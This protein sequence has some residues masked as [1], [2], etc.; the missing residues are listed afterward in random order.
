MVSHHRLDL[1]A[2]A[3]CSCHPLY[4]MNMKMLSFQTIVVNSAQAFLCQY[5][6]C[7]L[8]AIIHQA[9]PERVL[10]Q[11]MSKVRREYWC[12]ITDNRGSRLLAHQQAY[13]TKY[14]WLCGFCGGYAVASYNITLL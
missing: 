10:T 12:F 6:L 3:I 5:F 7:F 1:L 11:D 2:Y 14:S 9:L 13:Y 4:V 8:N